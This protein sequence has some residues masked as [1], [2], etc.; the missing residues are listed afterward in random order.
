MAKGRRSLAQYKAVKRTVKYLAY[1]PNAAAVIAVLRNA[2]DE[3]IEAIANAALN[4]REWDVHLTP[5]QK[6][7]FRA[8]SRTF[9]ILTDR[10][11]TIEEKRRHLLTRK[12]NVSSEHQEGGAF[13][14]AA[15]VV[16][17]VASVL[18]SIGSSFISRITGSNNKSE[19]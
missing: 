6:Q 7:L 8:N 17:L 19:E 12:R 1:A 9:D 18:G 2:P 13:P 16:P 15:V 11:R 10:R 3:V 5:S 4:A 14:L